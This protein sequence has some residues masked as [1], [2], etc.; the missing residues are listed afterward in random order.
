[1]NGRLSDGVISRTGWLLVHGHLASHQEDRYLVKSE[2][3]FCFLLQGPAS[4]HGRALSDFVTWCGDNSL[5]L[6]MTKPKEMILD[7]RR[8]PSRHN[9]RIINGE[10]LNLWTAID[11]RA[12]F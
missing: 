1:M 8:K 11:T 6:N 3:M 2:K 4:G 9:V 5:D 12:Q 7:F 10:K